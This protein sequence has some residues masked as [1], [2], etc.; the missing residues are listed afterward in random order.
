MRESNPRPLNLQP[1]ITTTELPPKG[2]IARTYYTSSPGLFSCACTYMYIYIANFDFDD[3]T[4]AALAPPINLLSVLCTRL[5]VYI[6]KVK[7]SSPSL[8]KFP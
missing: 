6:H 8:V 4:V 3:L 1:C 2:L 5:A 7:Y